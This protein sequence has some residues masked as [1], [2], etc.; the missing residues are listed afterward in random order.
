MAT[1]PRSPTAPAAPGAS[2]A[3]IVTQYLAGIT[4]VRAV[5]TDPA[6]GELIIVPSPL[7]NERLI[8][9]IDGMPCRNA[10]PEVII[11]AYRKRFIEHAR[12]LQ[13]HAGKKS[14]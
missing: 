6:S 2:D 4:E 10:Q 13:K 9:Q 11:L 12:L 14:R 5:L 7:D 1:R 3:D 8:D